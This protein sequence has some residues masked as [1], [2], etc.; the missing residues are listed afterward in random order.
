M[1]NPTAPD[2]SAANE[3]GRNFK[4]LVFTYYDVA[5]NVVQPTSLTN[6]RSI[7]RVDIQVVVETSGP[8]SNGSRPTYSLASRTIPRNAWAGSR[9]E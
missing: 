3:I 8:L 1:T 9:S 6:R 2:W 5:G 4:E 7:G